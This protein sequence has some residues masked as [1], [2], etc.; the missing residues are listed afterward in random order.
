MSYI[1]EILFFIKSKLMRL[2]IRRWCVISLTGAYVAFNGSIR[3]CEEVIE[4]LP[5]DIYTIVPCRKSFEY[6][7]E[8]NYER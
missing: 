4:M 2:F 6:I 8:L 7:K 3:K 1:F 5:G